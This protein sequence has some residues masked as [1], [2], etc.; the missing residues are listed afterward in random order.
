MIERKRNKFILLLILFLLV[1]II[2]VSI[3]AIDSFFDKYDLKFQAP[4]VFQKPVIVEE[5]K[6]ELTSPL[7]ELPEFLKRLESEQKEKKRDW[8]EVAKLII[9]GFKD[10]G[11]ERTLEA[12]K[13]AYCESKWEEWVIHINNNGSWDG[14]VFQ[15]N[16]IHN[17]PTEK[18][19]NAEDN[20]KE[21]KRIVEEQGWKA[22]VCQPY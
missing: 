18:V 21:A 3:I 11:K 9:D 19:F 1:S 22:W 2:I 13:V 10:L 5:R 7:V 6:Q 4:V 16:S 17:L 15:L 14:G 8:S 20:I 12:L